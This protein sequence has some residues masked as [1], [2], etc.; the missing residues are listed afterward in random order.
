MTDWRDRLQKII[1]ERGLNMKQL[2]LAAGLGET[3]VR[4][5]LKKVT[6]PRVDTVVA[7]AEQLGVTLTELLEGQAGGPRR[8][9][10]IGFVSAGEGWH[11]FDGDGPFDEIEV[12]ICGGSPVG[13]VVRGNSMFPVYR[14][15]DV[16]IGAKQP[17]A[18]IHKLIGRDCI[19]QTADGGRFVKFLAKGSIKGRFSL[20]SY[21]PMH[22]DLE[23]ALIEWAAPISVVIRAQ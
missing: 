4:D 19:L 14:D 9:P 18:N 13:L 16:L 11:S 2:S 15:G 20:K 10:L 8:V 1:D 6:S 21:N 3:A 7:V 22:P 12:A 5:M 23:N 17:T